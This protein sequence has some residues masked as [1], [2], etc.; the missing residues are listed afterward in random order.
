MAVATLCNP[1]SPWHCVAD[2]A[3]PSS[4]ATVLQ[5]QHGR[6]TRQAHTARPAP[7][8]AGVAGE[9]PRS[10]GRSH[11]VHRRRTPAPAP[12][13]SRGA[14]TFACSVT[15]TAGAEVIALGTIIG[16]IGAT[17]AKTLGL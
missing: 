15:G 1:V 14:G 6:P 16:I 2:S 8:A 7:Q 10:D 13:E 5:C 17:A 12:A 3:S 9:M 4:V 11:G